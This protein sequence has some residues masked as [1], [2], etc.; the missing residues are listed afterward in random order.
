MFR[1]FYGTL[2]ICSFLLGLSSCALHVKKDSVVDVDKP[3]NVSSVKETVSSFCENNDENFACPDGAVRIGITGDSNASF[4]VEDPFGLS[5]FVCVSSNDFYIDGSSIL[6]SETG[7]SLLDFNLSKITLPKH[8][9]QIK[10]NYAGELLARVE[11]SADFIKVKNIA[12]G[13]CSGE[14]E[15]FIVHSFY[16]KFLFCDEVVNLVPS[17]SVFSNRINIGIN[18]NGFFRLEGELYTVSDRFYITPEGLIKEVTS[19]RALTDGTEVITLPVGSDPKSFDINSEGICSALVDGTKVEFANLRLATFVNPVGLD[20]QTL[21]SSSV[22]RTSMNSGAS[23]LS[24]PG[25]AGVGSI[26]TGLPTINHNSIE[27]I[28]SETGVMVRLKLSLP[29]ERWFVLRNNAVSSDGLQMEQYAYTKE[30]WFATRRSDGVLVSVSNKLPLVGQS[31]LIKL[32]DGDVDFSTFE[33]SKTGMISVLIDNVRVDIDRPIMVSASNSS[34]FIKSNVAGVFFWNEEAGSLVTSSSGIGLQ[35]IYISDPS[36][37]C[38]ENEA[39]SNTKLSNIQVID[40]AREKGMMACEYS[41]SPRYAGIILGEEATFDGEIHY[42]DVTN[43]CGEE[44]GRRFSLVLQPESTNSL[45]T[46][47]DRLVLPGVQTEVFDYIDQDPIKVKVHAINGNTRTY[48][49]FVVVII[50]QPMRL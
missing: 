38:R 8:T 33:I 37:S 11:G 36:P 7:S 6:S 46:V 25:Q 2:V 20:R 13:T 42:Y 28:S 32:P 50:E 1:S 16:S 40:V 35:K 18:G 17:D 26:I 21:V 34:G 24:A 3:N 27:N 22:Y 12:V 15:F 49:L 4:I 43:N 41:L 44:E 5:P 30:P 9:V 47:N 48:F 39:R 23:V 31:G 19:G 10:V 14:E 29:S 45:M